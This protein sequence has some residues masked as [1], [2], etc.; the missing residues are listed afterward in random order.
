M[1][2]I[3]NDRPD[4]SPTLNKINTYSSYT[5]VIKNGKVFETNLYTDRLALLEQL[6]AVNAI[7]LHA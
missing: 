4:L 7:L 5:S 1:L 2:H 6:G 3:R